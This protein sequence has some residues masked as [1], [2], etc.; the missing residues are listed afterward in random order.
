MSNLYDDPAP[1]NIPPSVPFQ[2]CPLMR[3]SCCKDNCA[4]YDEVHG[5]CAV[6]TLQRLEETRNEY[7]RRK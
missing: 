4:W 7:L 5:L 2:Y 1:V 6:L 3:C